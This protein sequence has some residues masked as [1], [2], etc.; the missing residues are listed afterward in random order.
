MFCKT[1]KI[2]LFTLIFSL[3]A[4][5]IYASETIAIYINGEK[6]NSDPPAQVINGRVMVPIRFVAENL[7]ATV[8]WSDNSVVISKDSNSNFK[9]IKL[10]GEQTTWPYWYDDG[11]LFM[12]YRDTLQLIKECHPHPSYV[13]Q[14]L[15]NSSTILFD[16]RNYIV[17]YKEAGD[18]RVISINYLKNQNIINYNWNAATGEMTIIF[19]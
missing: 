9:L 10:N 15:K 12:E 1:T 11:V 4:G 8:N 2:V 18:F 5:A 17:P 13:A 16:G 6:L 3:F 14:Y 19:I 7:G